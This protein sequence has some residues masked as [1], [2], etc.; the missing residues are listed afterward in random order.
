MIKSGRFS[1]HLYFSYQQVCGLVFALFSD[2]NPHKTGILADCILDKMSVL[3]DAHTP[4]KTPFV[5]S[6]VVSNS[7]LAFLPKA[8]FRTKESGKRR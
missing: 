8:I 6:L 1:S 3:A 5:S 4:H 7:A 2:R